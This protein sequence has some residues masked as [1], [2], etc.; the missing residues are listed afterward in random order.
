VNDPLPTLDANGWSHRAHAEAQAL[1]Q[2]AGIQEPYSPW[3]ASMLAVAWLQGFNLGAHETLGE[4]EKAFQR[5]Q[6]DLS[7]HV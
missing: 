7:G 3:F 1:L 4:A 2:D 6:E 5:L